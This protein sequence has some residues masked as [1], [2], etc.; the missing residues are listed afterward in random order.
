[1]NA[2]KPAPPARWISLSVTTITFMLCA[3]MSV[4]LFTYGHSQ[5]IFYVASYIAIFV[6]FY[7]LFNSELRP[8]ANKYVLLLTFTVFVFALIRFSWSIYIFEQFEHFTTPSE[9][10]LND[11]LLG[12]KRMMLGAFVIAVIAMY[13]KE[14]IERNRKYCKIIIFLGI[15]CGLIAGFHEYLLTGRRV[16]LTA[17]GASSSSYMVMFLYCT[18]LWLSVKESSKKWVWSDIVLFMMVCVLLA[19]CGTRVTFLSF[20]FITLCQISRFY[21]I[22]KV[23]QPKR[24]RLVAL[25]IVVAFTV[26]T[27]ERWMQGISNIEN[28][29]KNSSTSIGAR[30]AIWDAGLHFAISNFGFTSPDSR[31]NES[32]KYISRFHPGNKEGYK[33]VKYNMHNE[34]IEVATLQG[35]VGLI[36]LILFYVVA[37]SIWA[38]RYELMGISMPIAA[39][40][41]MGMTDSVII[42][43]PTAMMFIMAVALCTIRPKHHHE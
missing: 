17:D 15:L 31:T 37:F 40:F 42:Y 11:Y 6:F 20:I 3:A 34:F 14:I 12:G 41:I 30:I 22:L 36:S 10:I 5:K 24:N 33:N 1:M 8:R 13:N 25:I 27:G 29:D 2:N 23:L 19:L 38:K 35:L 43:A 7:T 4:N 21:G 28:Y 9:N 16:K 26:S 18:Y 32:R 39:L